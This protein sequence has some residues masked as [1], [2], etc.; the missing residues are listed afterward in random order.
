MTNLDFIYK[1]HSVRKFKEDDVPTKDIEEIIR[2]ASHAPSG[3]NVQ[4]WHFV[5]IKNKALINEMAKTVKNKNY[6]L[7]GYLPLEDGE[8]FKKFLRFSDFFKNAPV[9]IAVYA[10]EYIPTGMDI[11]KK[12][13]APAEEIE[14]LAFSNPGIQ[15]IGAAIENLMLA[16][17]NMGYGCCWMTSI[18]YAGKELEKAI[19]FQK[20]GYSLVALVPM[21]I[22]K[23]E[24]KSPPRK[25]LDEVMTIIK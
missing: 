23:G 17:S 24:I 9:A 4:N 14:K 21:G 3:K 6:E 8:K 12:I 15:N 19:G 25:N 18:N 2:A 1:R 20:Q 22:P 13:N 10:S 7:A 11:L 5:V 16:A